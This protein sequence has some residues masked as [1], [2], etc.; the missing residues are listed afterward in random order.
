ML[1]PFYR[2]RSCSEVHC[3]NLLTRQGVKLTSS[4]SQPKPQDCS[5]LMLVFISQW[6]LWTSLHQKPV[7]FLQLL[8][9]HNCFQWLNY[10]LFCYHTDLFSSS[11]RKTL[12]GM[13]DI[14]ILLTFNITQEAELS[15][16]EV[17]KKNEAQ[18]INCINL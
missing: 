18:I 9:L 15:N 11:S 13:I 1:Y 2:W 5:L 4:A 14:L 16:N 8:F 10:T 7:S 17:K 12:K 3:G 6:D